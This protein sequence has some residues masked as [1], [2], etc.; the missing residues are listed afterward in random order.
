MRKMIAVVAMLLVTA[1][2]ASAQGGGGGGG[3][4]MQM[5]PE[6]RDSVQLSR[7]FTGITL[8]ADQT[9]KAKGIIKTAREGTASLDRQ[10]PDYRDKMTA[11]NAKR[12]ADLKALLTADAD[13]AKFDENAAAA[14][15]G[16]GRGGL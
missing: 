5:S 4:G 10:A 6:A 1:G 9:T 7:L 8:N 16:R 3:G 12:N 11:A 14:G 13:K 2:A 15:R